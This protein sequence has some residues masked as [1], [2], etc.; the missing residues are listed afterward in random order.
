MEVI[1]V[2]AGG[3]GK[4]LLSLIKKIN[5]IAVIGYID[6]EN[7]GEKLNIPYLGTDS[8]VSE[9]AVKN[10]LIGYSFTGRNPIDS[11]RLK[12]INLLEK[13]GF[14]FPIVISSNAIVDDTST[15]NNGTYVFNSVIIN[16]N[17]RIGKY[18]VINT[19]TIIEH[20]V[21]IGNNVQI[22]TGGIIAGNVSISDNVYIGT[23][24]IIR[25]GLSITGN[26][27]IGMGSIVTKD[28]TN[29]GIYFGNP[30]KKKLT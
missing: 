21:N 29:P 15:I 2:G 17:T 9:L 16:N 28:I 19:G 11:K 10:A 24:S 4:S 23:G 30:A 5:D 25:D 6:K 12:L 13:E 8:N 27:I 18:C 7:K 1:L 3:H 14:Y 20:D 22:A 26:V